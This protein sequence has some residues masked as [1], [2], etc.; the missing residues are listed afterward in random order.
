M[1]N[2][3]AITEASRAG[4]AAPQEKIAWQG[5]DALL[6]ALYGPGHGLDDFLSWLGLDEREVALLKREC[7]KAYTERFLLSVGT[8]LKDRQIFQTLLLHYG[9][10]QGKKFTLDQTAALLGLSSEQVSKLQARGLHRLRWLRNQLEHQALV[11]A[12]DLL[13]SCGHA[14]RWLT[15]VLSLIKLPSPPLDIVETVENTVAGHRVGP[16]DIPVDAIG[17]T[18]RVCNALRPRGDRIDR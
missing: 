16:D 17:L 18:S 3:I 15:N 8:I 7:L 11:A 1:S 12:L 10:I 13:D 4:S 5:I 9:L 2:T 14:P 6:E